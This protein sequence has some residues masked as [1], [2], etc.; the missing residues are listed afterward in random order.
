MIQQDHP[1]GGRYRR[2]A[3]AI[4]IL[5]LFVPLVTWSVSV[6]ISVSSIALGLL[7]TFGYDAG[8]RMMAIRKTVNLVKEEPI[9]MMHGVKVASGTKGH[10]V[11]TKNFLLFVPVW[12]RIKFVTENERV[13][14]HE[15]DGRQLDLTVKLPKKHR[16]FHYYVSQPQEMQAML[17]DV[18]GP[19]LPYKYDKRANLSDHVDQ[20]EL[21]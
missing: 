20:E 1:F 19:S 14:R 3:L 13:V 8:A 16:S 7:L 11:L 12:K 5:I 6:A 18:V 10:M 21:R 17:N 15:I 4:L 9:L 2:Y